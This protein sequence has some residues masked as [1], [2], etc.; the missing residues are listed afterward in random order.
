MMVCQC[1]AITDHDIRAADQD[2]LITP[3][4][5][6]RAQG[7]RAECG[8]CVALFQEPMASCDRPP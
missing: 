8:G 4:K 1:H 7:K 6:Y 2:R 3:G 5:I